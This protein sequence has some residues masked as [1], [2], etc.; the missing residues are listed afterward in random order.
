LKFEHVNNFSENLPD[1]KTTNVNGK[2]YYVTPENDIFPSVTTVLSIQ[3]QEG[4]QQWRR[5][6]GDGAAD[7]IMRLAAVRGNAFHKIEEDYLGNKDIS[8]HNNKVLPMAL[9]ER[10]KPQLDRID[11]IHAL[12]KTLY[13]N[14]Y[15]I[16]G[17]VDCIADFDNT[18]SVIDFK[19]STRKKQPSWIESYY[20]Q[21]TAYS[22]MWEEQ[23]DIPIGQIVTII[24]SEDGA[25]QTFIE[26]RDNFVSKLKEC[27]S[28]Y[29]LHENMMREKTTS[30]GNP[31]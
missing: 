19:T 1:L 26:H 30:M 24:A 4:I 22:L 20:L 14:N 16:A 7:S 13:S 31:E 29:S 3:N 6:V 25:V 12:E 15:S 18:L 11:N 8:I 21:E 28:N 27:I 17:R 5:N 10:A 2:R 23:T 9:F